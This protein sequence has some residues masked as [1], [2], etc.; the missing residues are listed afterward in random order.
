MS[1]RSQG[2]KRLSLAD[3]RQTPEGEK[4]NIFEIIPKAGFC[5]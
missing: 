2:E 1:A 3:Q 5:L 4:L